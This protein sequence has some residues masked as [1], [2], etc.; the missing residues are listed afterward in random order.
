MTFNDPNTGQELTITS[1]IGNELPGATLELTGT[2]PVA[3]EL[4]WNSTGLAPGN[5]PFTITATDNA[6]PVVG[7]QQYAYVI[8]VGASG[9]AGSDAEL[10]VCENQGS[11]PLFDALGGDP[12]PNGTWVDPEGAPMNGY[13]EPGTSDPGDYVYTVASA[14]G[15]TSSAVV[16]VAVLPAN[17]PECV[18]AGLGEQVMEGL[19]IR[20][21]DPFTARLSIRSA[22]RLDADLDVFTVDG[23]AE[24]SE[25]LLIEPSTTLGVDLPG[26]ASGLR[27]IHITDRASGQRRTLRLVW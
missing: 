17:I 6:C 20:Q 16:S 18:G 13:F 3:A 15:C 23:R 25:R 22:H 21:D 5:Y 26:P 19:S 24:F 12:S 2:N 7:V 8:K 27:L 11:V 9:L 1:D 14:S 10:D 4:C